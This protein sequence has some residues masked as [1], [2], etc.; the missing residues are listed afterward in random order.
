MREIQSMY[1]VSFVKLSERFFK[2]Q[3]W[4][5]V[6]AISP[7]VDHD[8][9]FCMLYK[10][11]T[12][13][14]EC[15][16][17]VHCFCSEPLHSCLCSS[18]RAIVSAQCVQPVVEANMVYCVAQEMYYRHLYAINQPSLQARFESWENYTALFGVI[19]HGNVNMQLP[20]NWLWDMIDEFVYQFQVPHHAPRAA[21]QLGCCFVNH[22]WHHH[23]MP[24]R[25]H[26]FVA[27]RAPAQCVLDTASYADHNTFESLVVGCSRSLSTAASCR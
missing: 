26:A 10:V 14:L 3:S 22:L 8:N 24:V 17:S 6:E 21:V 1:E 19:L 13:R 12:L 27:G 16:A 20:N 5:A 15:A 18:P 2:G 25:P 23:G 7:L 11:T 4:P 9:V